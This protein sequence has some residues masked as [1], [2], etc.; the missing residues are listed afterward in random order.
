MITSGSI[1]SYLD[2]EKIN[3]TTFN[4]INMKLTMPFVLTKPM[5]L[6]EINKSM[7]NITKII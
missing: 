5:S 6:K 2:N 4:E 3:I 1:V 7:N